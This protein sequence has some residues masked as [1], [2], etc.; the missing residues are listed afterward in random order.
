MPQGGIHKDESPRQAAVRE[1]EEEIGTSDVRVLGESQSWYSYDL[2]EHLTGKIWNGEYR[3]QIQKLFAM[4]YLGKDSTI[5]TS[6]VD[7]PEFS[8]WRWV[9]LI[10]LPSLAVYFKKDIYQAIVHE[11][12]TL[13][14]NLGKS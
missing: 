12:A 3:G 1:L 9:E 14:S 4:E 2:P 7:N 10:T 6:G 8:E 5:N 13:A 11:F